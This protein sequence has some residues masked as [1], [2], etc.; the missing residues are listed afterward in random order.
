MLERE[1]TETSN[2][3]FLKK[4]LIVM[5]RFFH[6][7]SFSLL[8]LIVIG[9]FIPET[10]FSQTENLGIVNYTPPKDWTKT[11]KENI[12]SFSELNQTTGAFCIITLY[13][14]T[15]GTGNPEKD[16]KRE[17]NNLVVAPFKGEVNP[18]TETEAENGWTAIAGGTSIE[19]QGVKSAAFLTVISGGG[20][21]ISILSVFNNQ[22]YAAHIA[23]FTSKIELGKAV[24]EAPTAPRE[25]APTASTSNVLEMHAAALV[26]EF[27]NNEIRANQTFIGKRVRIHGTINTI[28]IAR[29][30][31]VVLTYKSSITTRNNARC[32]F[33]KA[34][35]DRVALLTANEQGTV[36]GTV[37]GLGDGFDGAK[38]FL[39]LKDCIVP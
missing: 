2:E 27:E 39:V 15:P 3:I 20:K 26:K 34:G 23:A 38:A 28:E 24:A 13:G 8:V 30:G 16:F 36:E 21:A 33:S 17:W 29:D 14:A 12:I 10:A 25:D 6:K 9:M 22:S 37:K 32:Y 35:S 19:F 11:T 1:L 18:E 7:L 31:Q 4:E 5:T